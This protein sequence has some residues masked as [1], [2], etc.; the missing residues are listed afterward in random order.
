MLRFCARL[1]YQ[2]ALLCGLLLTLACDAQAGLFSNSSAGYAEPHG[3]AITSRTDP[4]SPVSSVSIT[5]PL[6]VAAAAGNAAASYGALHAASTSIVGGDGQARAGA[7]SSWI[8]SVTVSS[9]LSGAATARG[10]FNLSGALS[11]RVGGTSTAAFA[12]STVGASVVVGG[13]Q[14]FSVGAQLLHRNASNSDFDIDSTS[15]SGRNVSYAPGSLAGSYSFDIPFTLGT[16]FQLF[17]NLTAETRAFGS[18]GLDDVAANSNFASTGT[19]GG[20]SDVRLAD[21]TVVSDFS[22]GSDSGFD[23]AHAYSAVLPPVPA[24][25]EPG[26]FALF[27][28]GLGF[29]GCALRRRPRMS[30]P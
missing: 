19:W 4:T 29:I 3:D 9:S 28:A 16:P 10:T 20:I 27:M 21:G 6:G 2:P 1:D 25:P 26:T 12:N 7:S 18:S 5:G 14:V 8:D 24:V 30:A 17:A 11:S 13:V 23:W 15:V 22:V